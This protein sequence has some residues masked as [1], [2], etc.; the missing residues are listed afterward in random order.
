MGALKN[1]VDVVLWPVYVL[2]SHQIQSAHKENI[3]IHTAD[4]FVTNKCSHKKLH[5]KKCHRVTTNVKAK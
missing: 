2:P 5:F 4:P 3:K 1:S